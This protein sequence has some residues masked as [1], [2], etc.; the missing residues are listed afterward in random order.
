MAYAT[1]SLGLE[2]YALFVCS[3]LPYDSV[4]WLFQRK[5]HTGLG[6]AWIGQGELGLPDIG[7]VLLASSQTLPLEAPWGSIGRCDQYLHTSV[8]YQ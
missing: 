2:F 1:A 3:K 7:G 4:G 5:S 6:V 8:I